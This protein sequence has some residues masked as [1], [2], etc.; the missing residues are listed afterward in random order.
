MEGPALIELESSDHR[1]NPYPVY[2]TGEVGIEAH[3]KRVHGGRTH[4]LRRETVPVVYD[5]DRKCRP[6]HSTDC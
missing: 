3:L 2:G 6:P 4:H 1:R 5:P